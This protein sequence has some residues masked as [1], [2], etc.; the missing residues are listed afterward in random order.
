MEE[1]LTRWREMGNRNGSASG[2]QSL[3]DIAWYQGDYAAARAFQE[4][5]LA[6]RSEVGND[7]DIFATGNLHNLGR[8]ARVEGD[9]ERAT[10]LCEASLALARKSGFQVAEIWA[11]HDLGK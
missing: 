10:A 7:I 8:I 9:Y 6:L 2:L 11:L 4:Q 3:G 1:C 5:S